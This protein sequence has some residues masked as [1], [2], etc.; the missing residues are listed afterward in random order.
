VAVVTPVQRRAGRSASSAV[1]VR[2][3]VRQYPIPEFVAEVKA[4]FP[5][6]GIAN[7]DEARV[8]IA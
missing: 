3:Y 5:D 4:A 1:V 6:Q 8:S 7:P 2:A